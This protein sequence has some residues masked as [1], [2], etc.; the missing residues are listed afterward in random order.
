MSQTFK[1][2]HVHVLNHNVIGEKYH[3]H[4]SMWSA[5]QYVLVYYNWHG[6]RLN[7]NDVA[8]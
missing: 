6:Y 2:V 3:H 5:I 4:F 7:M 8:L 1:T